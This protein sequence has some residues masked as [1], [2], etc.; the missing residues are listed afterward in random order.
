MHAV[1]ADEVSHKQAV[2]VCDL[3][4]MHCQKRIPANAKDSSEV[5]QHAEN[6][7]RAMSDSQSGTCD[8]FYSNGRC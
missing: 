2:V 1:F 7:D 8:C 4:Q 3:L 6:V 5:D